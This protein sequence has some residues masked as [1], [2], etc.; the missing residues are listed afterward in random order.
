MQLCF[1]YICSICGLSPCFTLFFPFQSHLPSY[2][3]LLTSM[4]DCGSANLGIISLNSKCLLTSLQVCQIIS[5]NPLG[6]SILLNP[7]PKYIYLVTTEIHGN[8]FHVRLMQFSPLHKTVLRW[9]IR[10]LI[11]IRNEWNDDSKMYDP[12]MYSQN[13]LW[14]WVVHVDTR[15]RRPV[16]FRYF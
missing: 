13:S 2:H 9:H 4:F 7:C 12:S 14:M 1:C 10:L 15:L 5:F 6:S 3:S 16:S 11:G 8:L